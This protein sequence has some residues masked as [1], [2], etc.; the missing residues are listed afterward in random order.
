MHLRLALKNGLS[1]HRLVVAGDASPSASGRQLAQAPAAQTSPRDQRAALRAR[2]RTHGSS[3]WQSATE[4]RECHNQSAG[5][6]LSGRPDLIALLAM[7]TAAP[8]YA[9]GASHRQAPREIR[10]PMGARHSSRGYQDATT[11]RLSDLGGVMQAHRLVPGTIPTP[12]SPV[13]DTHTAL[14]PSNKRRPDGRHRDIWCG[15][16]T[17][18]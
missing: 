2:Y 14:W 9:R 3:A 8:T 15:A 17:H 18:Q 13:A 4:S 10:R 16:Q 7:H 6:R 5:A 11:A 12:N 1:G